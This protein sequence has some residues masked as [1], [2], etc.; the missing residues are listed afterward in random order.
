M[1]LTNEQKKQVPHYGDFVTGSLMAGLEAIM[2][3]N[4]AA[5]TEQQINAVV[6]T[7]FTVADVAGERMWAIWNGP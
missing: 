6:D 3:I 5:P 1:P 2:N 4:Q 7:A